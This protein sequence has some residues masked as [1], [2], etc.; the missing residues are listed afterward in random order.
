[1]GMGEI[2]EKRPDLIRKTPFYSTFHF[3]EHDNP[4][5]RGL[6]ARMLGRI[7]ATEASFQL[8][9]LQNDQSEIIIYE[10]GEPVTTTV[11]VLVA[12]AVTTIHN[13]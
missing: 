7:K 6:M 12:E 3:M 8:M 2:A 10:H 1:M 4:V 9:A 5:L 13:S 11:A